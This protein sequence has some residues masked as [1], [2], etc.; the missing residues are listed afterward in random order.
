MKQRIITAIIA[1]IVFLPFLI[2]GGWPFVIFGYFLATVALFELLRMNKHIKTKAPYII[3]TVILWLLL[4][5]SLTDLN[6]V[7]ALE[8][9]DVLI[10]FMMLLLFYTV[11]SKNAFTF[12]EGSFVFLATIYLAIGF[13]FLIETRLLGL[14]YILFVLFVIWATDTGAYFSGRFF[15]KRKLWPIISPNKTIEGAVG[16]L[17]IAIVVAVIFQMIYP[18]DY[19]FG[20]MIFTSAVISIIGQI[21]DLV[22]SAI[23]RTYA[24]KDS[25]NILPGHGGILDRLDSLIFVIPILYIINFI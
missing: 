6:Q 19:S 22:A 3:A 25:G 4:F 15:G 12:N 16:G 7:L 11:A 14:E 1:L 9:Q 8:K 2:Y 17:I 21:G 5:P 23:K 13:Y 24:I 20:Y 18:F 10:I